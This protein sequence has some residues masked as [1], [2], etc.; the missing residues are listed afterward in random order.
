MSGVG[1]A[2]ITSAEGKTLGVGL[3]GV[4]EGEVFSSG[5]GSQLA[6]EWK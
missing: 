1:T 5:V 6:L 3:V 4:M 2:A